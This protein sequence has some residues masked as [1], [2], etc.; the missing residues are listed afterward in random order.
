MGFDIIRDSTL[1]QIINKVSGGRLLPYADERGDYT[2]PNRY[3]LEDT[4]HA[5]P[6]PDYVEFLKPE[7]SASSK[8]ST[9]NLL[10]STAQEIPRVPPIGDLVPVHKPSIATLVAGHDE[11]DKV[12]EVDISDA[13]RIPHIPE[14]DRLSPIGDLVPTHKPS[15]ATLVESNPE[16]MAIPLDKVEERPVEIDISNIDLEAASINTVPVLDE[17]RKVEFV[18]PHAS[19]VE[20]PVAPFLVTW[21]GPNDPDNPK[22]VVKYLCI[23][24]YLNR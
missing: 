16:A 20:I 3:L 13:L 5:E 10:I 4:W 11:N 7:K 24:A 2:V 22:Y 9:F 6:H 23:Y 12:E 15:I 18:S 14:V 17:K 1:G 19:E 21:D 8:E